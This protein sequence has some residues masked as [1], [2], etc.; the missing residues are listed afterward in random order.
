MKRIKV[1]IQNGKITTEA[2]GYK[3]GACQNPLQKL[4]E[5][6]HAEVLSE[7]ITE[8]GCLPDQTCESEQALENHA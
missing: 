4:T 2:E 6:L 5:A 8:E 1:T 3:G 7:E